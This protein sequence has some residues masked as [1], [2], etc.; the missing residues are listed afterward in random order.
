MACTT[1]LAPLHPSFKA[2]LREIDANAHAYRGHTVAQVLEAIDRNEP[3]AQEYAEYLLTVALRGFQKSYYNDLSP[4][5]SPL[6]KE[7]L[8]AALRNGPR[9][10]FKWWFA[11]V[12]PEAVVWEFMSGPYTARQMLEDLELTG[13]PGVRILSD[14]LRSVRDLTSRQ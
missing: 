12:E 9:F 2:L 7:T 5:A 6:Q 11:Q 14:V 1:A 13:S 8:Q 4:P 3:L 10:L